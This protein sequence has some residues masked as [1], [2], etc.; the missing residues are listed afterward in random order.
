MEDKIITEKNDYGSA[1]QVIGDS[2]EPGVDE[3]DGNQEDTQGDENKVIERKGHPTT[4][5]SSRI[6]VKGGKM[7]GEAKTFI[8]FQSF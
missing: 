6:R 8:K 4:I 1:D 2:I 7:P 3:R 5:S